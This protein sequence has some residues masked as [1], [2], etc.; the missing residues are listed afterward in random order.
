MKSSVNSIKKPTFFFLNS[1]KKSHPTKASLPPNNFFFYLNRDEKAR[2]IPV[3]TG[4]KCYGNLFE[5]VPHDFQYVS[6]IWC[7][8]GQGRHGHWKTPDG[9]Q[10]DAESK[11]YG[12]FLEKDSHCAKQ[13]TNGG[14]IARM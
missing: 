6:C 1:K 2:H 13:K 8:V 12:H 3:D 11:I 7:L 5:P 9:G 4:Q 14:Q 10:L